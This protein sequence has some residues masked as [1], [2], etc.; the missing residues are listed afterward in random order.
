MSTLSD[1]TSCPRC[2]ELERENA[3]LKARVAA[4][5]ER[6]EALERAGKRQAAPFRVPDEKRSAAPKPPGRKPGHPGSYRARP[7]R[8]DEEVEAPLGLCPHCGGLA[9]DVRRI[10]QYVEELPEPVAPRVTRVVTYRGRCRRCGAL[11]HS[12]HPLQ[13]S[14]AA[15]AAG[16]HLGPRALSLAAEL[17]HDLG[18]TVRKACRVLKHGFGLRVSPGG[19]TQ[20]LARVAERLEGA[21]EGLVPRLRASPAVYADE[22]SWWV[23]GP[24]YWLWVFT[25]P[26]CT[27]YKIEGRRG[28]AVVDEVLGEGFQGVLVSDCLSSYDPIE[29][30]KHKCY[31]HHLRA[32]AQGLERAPDSA[33]L[34]KVRLLL[35]T[36]TALG[37]LREALP[38]F[39]RHRQGLEAWADRLLRH[40]RD[41]PE[42]ERVAQRLRKQRP[43]L[44]RFLHEEGVEPTNNRAERQLRPAVIARK[45]SCGN[46]TPAGKHTA[47]ILMSLAASA[48]QQG[49]GLNDLVLAAFAGSDPLDLLCPNPAR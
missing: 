35:H 26:R 4:L 18:L 46:K 30:K 22:T 34:K 27:L 39:A 9:R 44:F 6:L 11:W 5:E 16:V 45:L 40:A 1:S 23:G 15:G 47:E 12:R 13:V 17:R 31:A 19:L 41:N 48:R 29:C 42:E 32:V 28:Q 21:Y 8:V 20:A 2:A 7:L 36:A 33:W 37:A 10:E 49:R 25:T 43:H 14:Q 24:G 3:E 38:D